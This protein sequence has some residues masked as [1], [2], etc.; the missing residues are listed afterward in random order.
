MSIKSMMKGIGKDASKA[1]ANAGSLAVIDFT[2]AKFVMGASLKEINGKNI[3]IDSLIMGVS[4]LGTSVVNSM[5]V[6]RMKLPKFIT[7]IESEF[8]V[9][10]VTIVLYI[11]GQFIYNKLSKRQSKG[12]VM[13]LFE[14]VGAILL[15]NYI[16]APIE[17][18][19]Q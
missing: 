10:L 7:V 19:L 17:N 3:A 2:N 1:L 5:I 11:L 16:A 9:D 12:M 18:L 8:G 4:T 13:S 15:G 6:T 14:A